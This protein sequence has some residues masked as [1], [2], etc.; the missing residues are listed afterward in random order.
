ML[1]AGV[2]RAK[3]PGLAE[4]LERER[5]DRGVR[6]GAGAAVALGLTSLV[7]AA[8]AFASLGQV[9]RLSLAEGAI[10]LPLGFGVHR[11]SRAAAVALLV[12]FLGTRL[13]AM[14]DAGKPVGWAWMLI[15]G[16]LFAV[17]ARAT[18]AHHRLA[19][20]RPPSAGPA[21]P[22]PSDLRA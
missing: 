11:R 13:A 4:W 22:N 3:A 14:L 12:Y 19:L 6:L 17:G 1:P 10:V 7:L 9:D 21:S 16:T 5:V 20:A 18:F 15:F 2:A 8:W